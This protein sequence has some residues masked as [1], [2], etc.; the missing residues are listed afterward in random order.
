ML[1][2]LCWQDHCQDA[3]SACRMVG[4]QESARIRILKFSECLTDIISIL[5]CL[6][7][8]VDEVF[9][10]R[11]IIGCLL[12]WLIQGNNC[13]HLLTFFF[14]LGCTTQ[15]LWWFVGSPPCTS[16]ASTAL[17][18]IRGVLNHRYQWLFLSLSLRWAS[19]SMTDGWS[20]FQA[21][22]VPSL[23]R[24]ISKYCWNSTLRLFK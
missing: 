3:H 6:N 7:N 2:E 1:S 22:T 8:V 23:T 17:F 21:D 19:S 24:L 12:G 13:S 10:S 9:S 4:L 18:T 11:L 5:E 20:D 14:F 16:M 15:L